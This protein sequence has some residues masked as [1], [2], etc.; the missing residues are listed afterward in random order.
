MLA[1]LLCAACTIPFGRYLHFPFTF[2]LH[3]DD[4][5]IRI[6]IK[7]KLS[8]NKAIAVMFIYIF[9]I[10]LCGNNPNYMSHFFFLSSF[11]YFSSIR[12]NNHQSRR[13]CV[14]VLSKYQMIL[15]RTTQNMGRSFST[16][17]KS[18]ILFRLAVLWLW[19]Q[20]FWI[21]EWIITISSNNQY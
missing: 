13:V 21:N 15:R 20:S 11:V 4:N 6:L 8:W 1:H 17:H 14:V 5:G 19:A 10:I 3:Q 2:S 16:F 12:S 9:G 18:I 7:E